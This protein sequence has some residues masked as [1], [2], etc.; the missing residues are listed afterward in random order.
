MQIKKFKITQHAC[1]RMAQRNIDLGELLFV[2]RFGR[3]EFRTGVIFYFL[4]ERDLPPGVG[5][6]YKRLVGTTVVLKGDFVTTVYRNPKGLRKI[7][8]KSK[9][10]YTNT[11]T[12]VVHTGHVT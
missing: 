2:M 1:Q 10:F 9:H 7:K 5:E 6:T 8:R 12:M 4:G 11:R 3:K